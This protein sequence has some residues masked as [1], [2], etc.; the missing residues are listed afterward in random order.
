MFF[1]LLLST[2]MQLCHRCYS[3]KKITCVTLCQVLPGY[4][5]RT[6]GDLL[7]DPFASACLPEVVAA[8]R[9]LLNQ[10]QPKAAELLRHVALAARRS[11]KLE[12]VLQKASQVT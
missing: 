5:Q 8:M 2:C 6:I 7:T 3:T 4:L 12:Q 9:P 11:T 10:L 1:A